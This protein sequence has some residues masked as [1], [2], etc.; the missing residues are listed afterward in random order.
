MLALGHPW[1]EQ[2]VQCWVLAGSER[3]QPHS[4]CPSLSPCVTANFPPP[5]LPF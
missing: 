1:E 2:V 3:P 5:G 4:S